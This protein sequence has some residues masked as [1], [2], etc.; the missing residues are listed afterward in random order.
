MKGTLG[1][2][3]ILSSGAVAVKTGLKVFKAVYQKTKSF[4]KAFNT[5]SVL[6]FDPS[7]TTIIS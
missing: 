7:S 3:N 1:S 5:S 2:G 4:T 6:S